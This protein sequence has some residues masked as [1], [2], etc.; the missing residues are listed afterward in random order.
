M[1]LAWFAS[2]AFALP[3]Y[4]GIVRDDVGMDCTPPCVLCHDSPM[5]GIGTVNSPFGAA[6]RDRGL[7]FEDPATVTAALDAM[8]ADAVDS[9]DDGVPDVD[10]LAEGGDPNGGEAFCASPGPYY[11]CLSHAPFPAGVFALGLAVGAQVGRARIG[12]RR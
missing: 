9:D 7:T 5:G 6:M 4:P 8:A 12:R 3:S 10:E 2:A 11:G 1:I